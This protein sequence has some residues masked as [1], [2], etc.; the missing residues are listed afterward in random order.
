LVHLDIKK[1]GRFWQVGTRVLDDGV[2]GSRRAGWSYAHVAIDDHSDSPK[3]S[4]DP[5]SAAQTA[6]PS[7]NT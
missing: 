7:P 1:L 4:Y 3:S 5:A 2:K 6:S